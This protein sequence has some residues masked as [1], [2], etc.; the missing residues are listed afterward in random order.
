M[1]EALEIQPIYLVRLSDWLCLNGLVERRPHARDRRE[2]RLD[3]TPTGRAT[4]TQL[5]PLGRAVAG[6]VLVHL[7]EAEV[8][9][10][11]RKLWRIGDNMCRATGERGSA[12]AAPAQWHQDHP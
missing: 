1:A 7:G 10:L 8:V 3:L 9:D 12:N 2:N 4:F 11:R 6:E 5:I